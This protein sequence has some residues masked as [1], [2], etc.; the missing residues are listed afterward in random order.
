MYYVYLLKCVDGSLYCGIT[1]DLQRRLSEHNTSKKGAKYTK[2]RRPVEIVWYQ[3]AANRSEATKIELQIKRLSRQDKIG[4]C[5]SPDNP[6]L[7]QD[8]FV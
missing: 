3:H 7:T 4:L 2:S 1:T 6:V 8:C 5:C